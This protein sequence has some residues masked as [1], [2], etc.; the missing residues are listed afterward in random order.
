[1]TIMRRRRGR[2]K[3]TTAMETWNTDIE[4]DTVMGSLSSNKLNCKRPKHHWYRCEV[5]GNKHKLMERRVV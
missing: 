1:M 4:H 2:R 5:R 3:T